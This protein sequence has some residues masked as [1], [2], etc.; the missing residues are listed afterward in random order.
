MGPSGLTYYA[1]QLGVF[2]Q[3]K[4]SDYF[5]PLAVDQIKLLRDPC[6]QIKD[7][8]TPRTRVV[9]LWNEMLKHYGEPLVPHGSPLAEVVN[10]LEG[11]AA[12]GYR[13]NVGIS[14]RMGIVALRCWAMWLNWFHQPR[15]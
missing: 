8:V 10:S 11:T 15:R 9:H 2:E 5:Y 12:R 13:L 7:L 1:K 4:P 6:L 14:A 3:A